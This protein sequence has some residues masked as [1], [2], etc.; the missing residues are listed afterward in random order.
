MAFIFICLVPL[1]EIRTQGIALAGRFVP[2]RRIA[3]Y[4]WE[5]KWG[6]F[7]LLRLAGI[8]LSID[9]RQTHFR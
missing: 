6:K 8:T 2:W 9:D 5:S 4:S 7:E 3:G 1:A